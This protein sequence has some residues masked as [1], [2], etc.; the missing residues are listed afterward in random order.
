MGVGD[1]NLPCRRASKVPII[2][3]RDIGKIRLSPVGWSAD[4]QTPARNAYC[5]SAPGR[6]LK[7]RV[8]PLRDE[9]PF[10]RH[11][12]DAT[13]EPQPQT[14]RRLVLAKILQWTPATHSRW[15]LMD[16]RYGREL[17]PN[18]FFEYIAECQDIPCYQP[19]GAHYPLVCQDRWNKSQF[20]TLVIYF[21][22]RKDI[23]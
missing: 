14:S 22:L 3:T 11:S 18:T 10:I 1:F 6:R 12:T 4:S 17:N 2:V 23:S 5:A 7:V 21:Q 9:S 19:F 13:V 15:A 20:E 8:G 16:L